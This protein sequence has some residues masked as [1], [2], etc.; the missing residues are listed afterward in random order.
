M[1]DLFFSLLFSFVFVPAAFSQIE[2][3]AGKWKTWVISSG[4]EIA[5]P[6]PP[7]GKVTKDEIKTLLALQAQRDEAVINKI[8]YWNAGAPSYRWD[9]MVKELAGPGMPPF[10]AMALLNVAI[11]DATVAAWHHKYTNN[12]MRPSKESANLHPYLPNPESPSYPCEHSVTAGAAAAV[13]AY[14]FPAK[15]DSIYQL[16][17]EAGKSRLSAGVQYPSDVQAGY[18]LGRQIGQKVVAWAKQDG[19]DV[20]WKGTLPNKPNQWRGKNPVGATLGTWKTWVLSS[21]NQ[22]RPGPPPDFAKDMEELKNFKLTQPAKARA[23]FYAT[24]DVWSDITN[25][26]IFEYNL[27]RDAPRAARVY[28]L[29]SIAAYDAAVACWDAKYTY[30][31]I[32]PYEYD[33]TYQQLLGQPSFPGYPSGHATTSNSVA[34]VLAYLFPHDAV[35]FKNKAVEC[36]ESRFEGGIHFRTD[37]TV[38][39][40]LG[41]K[42]ATL[43][44]NRAKQDGA[45]PV[46][47]TAGK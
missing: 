26:K 36:A 35:F 15:A 29:K 31:G 11:F 22:F 8:N 6:S 38:G 28:A 24:Q 9:E 5:L 4:S 46:I 40:D 7:N 37:N 25:K 44:I 39:L 12:R 13:L 16:A 23:F 1:K 30:W 19:A 2:P 45:D 17:Q 34:L 27:I 10:R 41:S 14:L 32:R 18:D 20:A 42:V 21:G 3:N 47:Q 43:V 33:T